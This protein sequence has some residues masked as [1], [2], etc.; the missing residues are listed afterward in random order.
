MDSP[1][2][3]LRRIGETVLSHVSAD[4]A[5]LQIDHSRETCTR[6]S[7][8]AIAQ[9][10]CTE[11]CQVTLAVSFG[12][13]VGKAEVVSTEDDTLRELVRRAEAS[14]RLMPSDPEY[15]P[16]LGP[17][18][19][20]S[21]QAYSEA[22]AGA[23][24]EETARMS[25]AMTAPARTAGMRASGTVETFS[26]ET[27]VVTSRGLYARHAHTGAQV[28]CTV[29]GDDSSGW[30][31]EAAVDIRDLDPSRL[32]QTAVE[33]ARKGSAPREITAGRYTVLLMPP[34]AGH[35]VSLLVWMAEARRTLEG[36]TYLSGRVGEKLAGDEITVYSD[37]QNRRVPFV[38]FDSAGIPHRR[39]VWIDRGVFA[40]MWWDRWTAR[41]N[42]VE[43]IPWPGSLCMA[44]TEATLDELIGRIENGVLVTHFWYVRPIKLDQ[45]LFT[46]MTRDGTFLIEDGRIQGGVK[47]LRFNDS[48]LGMLQRTLAVGRSEPCVTGIGEGVFPPLVVADWNFTGVTDF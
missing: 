25:R 46:G 39:A 29:H 28:G 10:G 6:F 33:Q 8:N 41:Q 23:T 12:D 22:T 17:Q 9:N 47:N 44:G 37:P 43:P 26:R 35:L 7:N 48:S 11:R 24:P 30:G 14:A 38:P 18:D 15:L 21:V 20:A 32:A 40:R 27:A 31:R 4:D 1:E 45:A 16:P 42:G 19:Y 5:L 36:L 2:D 13:R 34:A 3:N